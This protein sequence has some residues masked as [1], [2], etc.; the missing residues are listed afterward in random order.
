MRPTDRETLGDY[1]LRKLGKPVIE[2]NIAEEQ[3]SDRI[4]EAM[5]WFFEESDEGTYRAFI[6]KEIEQEDIDNGY[7]EVP[8][9][10]YSIHTM[11]DGGVFQEAGLFS[12]EYQIMSD[13]I[14]NS[15]FQIHDYNMMR[16]HLA[17]I[18]HQLNTTQF[19][20][21]RVMNRVFVDGNWNREENIG[22]HIVFEGYKIVDDD[23]EQLYDNIWLKEFATALIKEQWGSNI[24]KYDGVQLPG[25]VTM[26]GQQIYEEAREEIQRL[27]EELRSKHAAPA[28][29][30]MG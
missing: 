24:K 13:I 15:G 8:D 19:R 23:Y 28:P 17:E 22:K 18:D 14:L 16:Q 11:Y 26:N 29:F 21:N 9:S 30:L 4:E 12:A 2:I 25:G 6:T 7:I 20:F 3:V 1:C 5:Q 27:K 10:I